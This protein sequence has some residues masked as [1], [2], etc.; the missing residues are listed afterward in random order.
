MVIVLKEPDRHVDLG[1]PDLVVFVERCQICYQLAHTG[2]L[3]LC[4]DISITRER[5]KV[6]GEPSLSKAMIEYVGNK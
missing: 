6:G 3:A 2:S 5:S 1:D 4:T